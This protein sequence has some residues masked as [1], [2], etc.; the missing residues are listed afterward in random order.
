MSNSKTNSLEIK[1]IELKEYSCKQSEHNHLPR[2]PLRTI[3]LSPSG[4][5][6]TVLL[7]NLILHIY[8]GCFERIYIFSPSIDIDSTWSPVK[9]YQ[10]EIMKVDEKDK[11]YFDSYNPNE[12]ENIID[13]QHKVIKLMKENKRNKLFSILVVIDDFADDPSF[14]RQSKL[15]HSLYTRGRHNSIST[16][17][18]TQKFCAIH[19][20]IRVNAT[21][22][23]VYRLRNQKEVD[24]FL[25][26]VSGLITKK[27]LF[28]I[29]KQATHEEYSF[30]Y[31]NLVSKTINDMF[32]KCFT[33]KIILENE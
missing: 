9:K 22:L 2:I 21:S 10:S 13:T 27:D 1:P 24:S 11:L 31:V 12:L 17:V 28:E 6:K 14:T 20:I 16:I 7:S 33:T 18:S 8:R 30:L 26:E 25:E 23:I 32:Y 5:G 15:L 29:Y 4:G 3:I 19:P